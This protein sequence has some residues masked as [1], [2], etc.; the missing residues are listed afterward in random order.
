MFYVVSSI[1]AL[2]NMSVGNWL[3]GHEQTWWVA[4][5]GGAIMSVVWNYVVSSLIVWRSR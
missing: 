1:G 5:L 3:F 4:G 2:S